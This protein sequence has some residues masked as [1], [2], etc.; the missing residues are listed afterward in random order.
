MA[1]LAG[2]PPE[3][4]ESHP[5]PVVVFQSNDRFSIAL[6]TGS[7]ADAGIPFW[8]QD[9]ESA[10]G[11]VLGAIAFPI[12]R[13]LVDKDFEVQARQILEG[14]RQPPPGPG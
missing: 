4:R 8:I 3:A 2:D 12:C 6:A 10:S 9:E 7:L 1:L 13:L 11:L 14:Q 5:E